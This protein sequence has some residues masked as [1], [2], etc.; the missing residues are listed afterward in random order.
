MIS[1]IILAYN[2][3]QSISEYLPGWVNV[4]ET[5]A[6]PYEVIISDDGSKDDTSTIVAGFCKSNAN[7]RHVRSEKNYGVGAN[8][9]MGVRHAKGDL[10]AYTDGD[11]QY[12]P[13]DLLR[14]INKL[15]GCDMVTGRRVKRA[16]P[17]FRSITSAI[18][19]HL[20][21]LIYKVPVKD[22]NSGLKLFTRRYIDCCLPQ[23]SNGPFYDAEYLI[24]GYKKGMKIREVPIGHQ[25][26]KYGEAAGVSFRSVRFV[27]SEVCKKHM[28]PYTKNNYC[29]RMIFRLLAN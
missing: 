1:L 12:L 8:F 6:L 16:D 19:N 21:R 7:I 13:D 22:I 24:K 17:F 9:K 15:D 26:R 4:L 25:R 28:Q 23:L 18:Y 3:G 14:L 27:F 11:G 10:I 2:D 29:S 5:T 20:V